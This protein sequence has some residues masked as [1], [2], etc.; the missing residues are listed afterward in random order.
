MAKRN[1]CDVC[2]QPWCV[3][4]EWS[5]TSPEQYCVG[6]ML[7]PIDNQPGTTL[8]DWMPDC[9]RITHRVTRDLRGNPTVPPYRE[10]RYSSSRR[11]LQ[12]AIAE[13]DV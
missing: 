6:H 9:Q 3:R 7:E 11:Q 12:L 13:A 8:L 5:Y 4:F 2:E 1:Q 10:A